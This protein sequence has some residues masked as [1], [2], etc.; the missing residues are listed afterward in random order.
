MP[1]GGAPL[2]LL[3]IVSVFSQRLESYFDW[4][5]PVIDDHFLRRATAEFGT[6][7]V[8]DALAFRR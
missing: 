5:Q 6:R 2:L 7:R 4:E 8:C 3:H 1:L